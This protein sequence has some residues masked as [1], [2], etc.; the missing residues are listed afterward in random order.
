MIIRKEMEPS[1]P[2]AERMTR[3]ERDAVLFFMNAVC[4]LEDVCRDLAGRFEQVTDGIERMRTV[5]EAAAQILHEVKLTIPM[6]QR[7]SLDNVAGDYKMRL[8]PNASPVSNRNILVD[9]EDFRKLV[10]ASQEKC[11]ICTETDE[12]CVRCKLYQLLT[13]LLP[14]DEYHFSTMCPYNMAQWEN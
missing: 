3:R 14:M 2:D 5:S 4:I 11:V 10:D 7:K 8:V 13:V 12:T 9:K 6:D 1:H